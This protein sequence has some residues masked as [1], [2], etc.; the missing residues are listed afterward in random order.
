[1][2]ETVHVVFKTHLD[3]GFTDTAARVT[4]RYV[5]EFLPRAIALAEK[6]ERRDGDARFVWTTGSWLIHEALPLGS[7]AER[8]ALEQAIRTGHVRW[9]GLPMT[10]HSELMDAALFEHGIS[11]GRRLDERF[12]LHTIAA[13]M[14]DVPGHT[15]GIVPLLARAGLE[16]LHL[17]VNAASAVPDVP[18][19]FIWRAPDGSEV[20][21]NYARSYGATELGVAVA[22]GTTAALHLAHTGDNHGPP[23]VEEVE[24]L[25][26]RLR[27]E[28]PTA[29]IV[30]STL[31]AFAADVLAARTGLPVVDAEIGDSWIHG[32]ASDPVL[33]ARL[34]AL[35]RLRT[36]WLRSGALVA[37]S[38]ECD[39]FSDGLLLV[40]EHTWGKDLKTYL[41]DYVNYE[42]ADFRRARA[43]DIIDPA[44]NPAAFDAYAW[45]PAD[46]PDP[47]PL[48]YSGFEA[49][50]AE[51]RAHLDRA[52]AAL[53]PGRRAEALAA[54]GGTRPTAA[55]SASGA[56]VAIDLAQTHALGTYRVGFGDD[57]AIISLVDAEGT[58]WAGPQ[59]P[60]AAYRYQ[61]FDER[62]EAR[63]LREYCR[64]LD[65]NAFWAVPDQSK[66]GLDIADRMPAT[67]FSARVV[68]AHRIDGDEAATVVLDLALPERACR[69]W[70]APRGIRL[71]YRFPA[72]GEPISITLDLTGKDASRLPEAGWLG[73]RPRTAD[74]DWRLS[75]LDTPV[76]PQS[77]VRRG[78]R[79]L[80][81]VA[82]VTH[83]GERR[84]S[85]RPLD[86][87]LVAVGEPALLRFD[88]TLPEPG[89]GFHVNLHN[90]VWGTNFTMWLDDDLRFRFLLEL[91]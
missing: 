84:F 35:L 42:K 11:I 52:L 40:P 7:E 72:H 74:G 80:H 31:D 26:S 46:R 29:R 51:Q 86:A 17:G 1:M 55:D 45:A 34:R 66:P 78:G 15:I 88:D 90:N 63:W 75:K 25:F 43:I 67:V 27:S 56:C 48:S 61:T 60:L 36:E 73:F 18:E 8:H 87:A 79:P 89:D 57:G 44:A 76:D 69:D 3:L 64:D 41:P 62:D 2:I 28:Y 38:P 65:E 20:V 49:S 19:F 10:T 32:V 91:S 22:P 81:A 54:I 16:F 12:G 30:A 83:A 58:Q 37:G 14:T 6:L 23:A 82:E 70:G 24:A 68:S 5:H 59:H 33:T 47:A 53:S 21:V 13:K 50:W 85:L 9:H 39:A 4:A 77:V 71:R